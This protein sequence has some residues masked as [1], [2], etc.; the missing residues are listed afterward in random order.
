EAEQGRRRAMNARKLEACLVPEVT[1]EVDEEH[2][3]AQLGDAPPD[4]AIGDGITREQRRSRRKR[5]VRAR[6][7]SVK[8]MTKREL[9]IGRLL[10]PD[11]EDISRPGNREDCADGEAQWP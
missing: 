3:D 5:A 10:Y 4:F 1:L 9:E 8:R 6:T 11:V 7:I 2:A